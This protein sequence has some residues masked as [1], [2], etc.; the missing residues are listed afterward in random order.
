MKREYLA[1]VLTNY[2]GIIKNKRAERRL[3]WSTFR[4]SEF[5]SFYGT[6]IHGTTTASYDMNI[7]ITILKWGIS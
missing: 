4:N 3:K 1:H 2:V 5:R 7:N 6:S